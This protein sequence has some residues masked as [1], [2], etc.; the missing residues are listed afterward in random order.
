M[1]DESGTWSNEACLKVENCGVR[2]F[3]IKHNQ[4]NI[5]YKEFK[6]YDKLNHDN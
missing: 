6:L 1:I 3:R 2:I 4:K 5:F